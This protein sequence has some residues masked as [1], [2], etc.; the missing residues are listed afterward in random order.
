MPS[1]LG[2][3]AVASLEFALV[4]PLMGLMV[5]SVF[6]GAR[7][8]V[9][10]QETENAAQAVVQA[11]EKFSVVGNNTTPALTFTQMQQAMS[12]IYEEIPWIWPGDG[13]S[14]FPG[15]Y[16]VT[17]SEVVYLP[18]C[19]YSNIYACSTPQIPH[20]LW[21]TYLQEGGAKLLQSASYQR[22]CGALTREYPTWN[23]SVTGNPPLTRWNQMVDP[24]NGGAIGFVMTPQLVADVQYQFTPTFGKILPKGTTITFI[25]SAMLST[26]IGDNALPVIY[27]SSPNDTNVVNCN[28]P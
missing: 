2:R 27:T 19:H 6:D 28:P 1:S 5:L 21:S 12:T 3:R 8:L 24:S 26:P 9:A 25:A 4:A 18:Y 14:L 16:S 10:W 22:Q 17:L 23:N 11:A 7:A 15:N 20:T 13:T